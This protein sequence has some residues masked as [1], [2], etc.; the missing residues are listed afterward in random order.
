MRAM[1]I[2]YIGPKRA[3]DFQ[4]D[5]YISPI[6]SPP[7]LLAHFPPVYLICGEKDPFVD[8]TVIFAGKLREAKRSLRTEAMRKSS[9]KPARFGE[10][11]RMSS[12]SKPAE[13]TADER[14]L[15]ESDED[16]VVQMRIIEGWGHGFM[17]MVAL[18]REIDGV[19]SEMADWID[20]S[21]EKAAYRR[22]EDAVRAQVGAQA[23]AAFSPGRTVNQVPDILVPPT[24]VSPA[25]AYKP[26]PLD[27]IVGGA[28]LGTPVPSPGLTNDGD[29]IL[30]FTPKKRR[31]PPSST[32]S[33]ASASFSSEPVDS[34]LARHGV[35]RAEP[36]S[37][38]SSAP[39]FDDLYDFGGANGSS[40]PVEDPKAK[41]GRSFGLFGSGRSGGPSLAKSPPPSSAAARRISGGSATSAVPDRLGLVAA[42]AAGARAVSPA[43]A[44]FAGETANHV[45]QVE[46][47]RR[48]RA[49]AVLGMGETDSAMGSDTDD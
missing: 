42:A 17:Q 27:K 34:K 9:I 16:W 39:R 25:R 13:V 15:R 46:L 38:N 32:A 48:R 28:D 11:L 44:H 21:F 30:T 3:P 10:G 12:S 1:A 31:S 33:T 40:G 6:L 43:L 36:L 35:R 41:S 19:L 18:M 45:T 4:T 24:T 8:D 14:I 20:D 2:L 5:Y 22:H 23:Q 37:R 7:H 29:D 47:M 49:E 26:T